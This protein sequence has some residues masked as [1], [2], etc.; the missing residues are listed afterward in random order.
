VSI[1]HR[2]REAFFPVKSSIKTPNSSVP[3]RRGSIRRLQQVDDLI[4]RNKVGDI[5]DKRVFMQCEVLYVR[6]IRTDE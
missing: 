4:W 1:D 2:W 3:E 6:E 5:D